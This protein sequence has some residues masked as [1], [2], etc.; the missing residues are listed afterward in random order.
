MRPAPPPLTP[1]RRVRAAGFRLQ[2]FDLRTE[3]LWSRVWGMG[4]GVQGA[5]FRVHGAGCRVQGLEGG[6]QGAGCR[7]WGLGFRVQ[8]SEFRVQGSGF[9]VQGPGFRVQ[10]SGCRVSGT[11]CLVLGNGVW[12]LRLGFHLHARG[13]G[14]DAR[15]RERPPRRRRHLLSRIPLRV[16]KRSAV[17]WYRSQ[18]HERDVEHSS[19]SSQVRCRAKREQL[20]RF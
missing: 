16:I 12:G 3:D 2:G 7:F 14:R 6:L 4:V 10:G 1:V 11:E 15:E 18:N 19:S 5:G 8:G 13:H 20:E 17:W 9:R